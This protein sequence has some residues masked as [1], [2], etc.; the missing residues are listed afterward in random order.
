MFHPA[1]LLLAWLAF[2]LGLQWLNVFWLIA[3]AAICVILALVLAL[4]HTRA[5][6]RRSRWLL[7]SLVILYS[8]ATPGEY[9][10]GL[11]GTLGLTQEG[12]REGAEQ[13]GRLLAML[14]SLA[15]LHQR[16]GTPG[17]LTALYWLSRPLVGR[18]KT[19]VRLM[20]V[21]ET[22][23]RQR[24]ISWR[25]WLAPADPETSG[26]PVRLT[27]SMPPFHAADGGL[28]LLVAIVLIVLLAGS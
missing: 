19:V 26:L 21:L 28:S 27:L 25:E 6:L 7:L 1:S 5:L 3:V 12:I 11:G 16:L 23:E 14:A 17:L 24:E 22:V 15:L 13:V 4:R 8:F 10:P 2:A 9:L 20:L 18:D